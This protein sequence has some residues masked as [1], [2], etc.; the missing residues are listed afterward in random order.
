[1]IAKNKLSWNVHRS[2]QRIKTL[3]YVTLTPDNFWAATKVIPDRASGH[4]HERL[5]RRDTATERSWAAPIS[6]VERDITDISDRMCHTLVERDITDISDRM[7]QTLVERDITDI[8]D[9]MCHTLVQC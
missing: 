5:W 2:D 7:C 1:M 6:K 4:T 9:R 8:S 3:G